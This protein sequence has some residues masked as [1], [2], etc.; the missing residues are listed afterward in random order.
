MN[1]LSH[2][3]RTI[4]PRIK[5]HQAMLVVAAG[6]AATALAVGGDLGDAIRAGVAAGLAWALGRELH[7]DNQQAALVGALIGGLFE[8]VVGGAGFGVLWL[9]LVFLRIIIR[10]TGA[11]PTI[12]DLVLN[13]VIVGF[14]ADSLPGFIAALG[15][16]VAL[17]I[18]SELPL[19]PKRSLRPWSIAYAGAALVGLVLSSA[20]T[21]PVTPGAAWLLASIALLTATGLLGSP[22]PTAVGDID[23]VELNGGRLRLG[24]IELV[25][26]V[27]VIVVSSTGSG[28]TVIAP[29]FAAIVGA[30]A[31]SLKELV[32][33]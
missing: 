13:L 22:R 20:P 21:G 3:V 24:R 31:F 19:P 16:V 29:A 12:L 32:S 25:A 28:I 27:S 33:S 26:L 9:L 7:P 18:S 14:V 6:S 23:R 15:V 17:F 4:D 10:T 2:L 1:R 8:A 30:G 11:E 5:T